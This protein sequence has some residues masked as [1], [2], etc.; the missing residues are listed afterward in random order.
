MP[1]IAKFYNSNWAAF[2]GRGHN[3]RGRMLTMLELAVLALRQEA[4][5][6]KARAFK[7]YRSVEGRY[8]P[9]ESKNKAG[10]LVI[11]YVETIDQWMALW[12]P[13]GRG[14]SK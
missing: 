3:G 12:G 8:G 1:Q 5:N 6:G 14:W 9:Q 2:R 7:T 11:P 10:H 4:M 13:D